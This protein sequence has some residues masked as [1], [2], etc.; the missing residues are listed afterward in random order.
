MKDAIIS[1]VVVAMLVLLATGAYWFAY[2]QHEMK[3]KVQVLELKVDKLEST[4]VLIK[5][6]QDKRESIIKRL[7]K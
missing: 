7:D 2:A 4:Q 6:K 3:N 5:E 1:G